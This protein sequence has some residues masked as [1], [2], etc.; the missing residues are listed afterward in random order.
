MSPLYG[1]RGWKILPYAVQNLYN[2]QTEF[3]DEHGWELINKCDGN[4]PVDTDM[5]SAE[6]LNR[7]L[8]WSKGGLI[9]DC[10]KDSNGIM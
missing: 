7:Y 6:D 1:F 4:T 8:A 5:L 9:I 10:D 2:A 3:F